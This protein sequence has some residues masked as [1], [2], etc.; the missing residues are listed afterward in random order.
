M[1]L[2]QSINYLNSLIRLKKCFNILIEVEYLCKVLRQTIKYIIIVLLIGLAEHSHS[3]T[4][5]RNYI[6]YW[7]ETEWQFVFRKN[8]TYSRMSTGYYG[9]TLLSGKYKVKKDTLYIENFDGL[10]HCTISAEYYLHNDSTMI[11]KEHFHILRRIRV[12]KRNKKVVMCM[13]GVTEWQPDSIYIKYP[14]LLPRLDESSYKDRYWNTYEKYELGD[15]IQARVVDF[16]KGVEPDKQDLIYVDWHGHRSG[17]PAV[18]LLTNHYGDYF[19]VL[20][21]LFDKELQI[22]DNVLVTPQNCYYPYLKAE[23]KDYYRIKFMVEGV[24]R[25]LGD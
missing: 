3:Q 20:D 4:F 6:G 7:S 5:N 14:E 15:T 1:I 2:L 18:Y 9:N 11:D 23:F 10:A 19:V 16:I 22:G 24:V 17:S 12:V 8:G 21:C 25:K 13:T